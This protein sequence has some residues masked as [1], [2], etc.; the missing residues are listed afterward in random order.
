MQLALSPFLSNP[1]SVTHVVSDAEIWCD[2]Q[3]ADDSWIDSRNVTSVLNRATYCPPASIEKMDKAD[4][5]Y[6]IQETHALQLSWLYSLADHSLNAADATGL[7]GPV[8]GVAEWRYWA[9]CARLETVYFS[10]RDEENMDSSTQLVEVVILQEEIFAPE[11]MEID[12]PALIKLGRLLGLDLFGA[13]FRRDDSGLWM[14]DSATTFPSLPSE[15][16]K[17]ISAL[18]TCL[19]TKM[20]T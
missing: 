14:L 9:G 15:S 20:V 18:E 11:G 3:L 6:V 19:F 7:N 12:A 13:Y 8:L 10:S 5:D 1:T 2:I 16:E 4:S 17:F